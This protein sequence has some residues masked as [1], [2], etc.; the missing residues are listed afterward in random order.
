MLIVLMVVRLVLTAKVQGKP[1]QIPP[2][3]SSPLGCDQGRQIPARLSETNMKPQDMRCTG[4][5]AHPVC[6]AEDDVCIITA[7]AT[8][9]IPLQ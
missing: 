9:A 7:E 6:K 8:R 2:M 3:M 1:S 5:G 4:P